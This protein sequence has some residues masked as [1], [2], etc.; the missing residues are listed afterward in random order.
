MAPIRGQNR[1][2]GFNCTHRLTQVFRYGAAFG[3]QAPC[4]GFNT[5]GSL[6]QNVSFRVID[7][8]KP[9]TVEKCDDLKR[10]AREAN[11]NV[12]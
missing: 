5:I 12:R 4:G 1:F 9:Q 2:R 8:R 3:A 11:K 7:D 6:S 10:N